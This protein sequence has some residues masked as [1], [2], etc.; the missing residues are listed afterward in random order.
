MK[1]DD[2]VKCIEDVVIDWLLP[3]TQFYQHHR[4]FGLALMTSMQLVLDVELVGMVV[5]WYFKGNSF[6]YPLVL[7]VLGISKMLLNVLFNFMLD[8][9]SGKTH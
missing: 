7:V 1:P 2:A 6:R 8:F 3:V 9:V 5:F 4:G